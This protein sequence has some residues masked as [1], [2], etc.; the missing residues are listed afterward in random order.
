[1]RT[2]LLFGLGLAAL[3]SLVTACGSSGESRGAFEDPASTEP[4]PIDDGVI[5]G[6]G[7]DAPAP[8]PD[9]LGCAGKQ[10]TEALP[11][12]K[13]LADLSYTPATAEKY[14]LDALDRRYPIG[15]F[16][17]QGGLS[18][19]LAQQQGSCVDR[20]LHDR[21]T[22]KSVLSQ[23][24]T[25]VHE[26]GHFMDLGFGKGSQAAFVI[27]PDV[28]LTCSAGDTTKRGGKTFA[29]SLL[30]KD[31]Y[32][33]KRPACGAQV[34]LG[35]DSYADTYLD[36]SDTNT[37]FESGDQG[38]NS[39]LEEATQY[40]NS[41]ATSLAFKETFQGSKSSQRDG[42]LTFLW[43]VERYLQLAREDHP[44][45]YAALSQD[46]CW[47]QAILTVWDRGWFYLAAT[48]GEENLGLDDT[49]IEPLVRDASLV[50]EIDALRKLE[51]Q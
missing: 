17:V 14:L 42:I 45:A 31:A 20:F 36:G 22:A 37:A 50:A 32:Y 4:A 2:S 47:R 10:Y 9:R 25:V 5:P 26:C 41:L 30:R 8:Q 23:A 7:G 24:Q 48:A 40:V 33:G 39:L 11:S 21:A 16:L 38:F 43:Y 15:K 3:T 13:S 6:G 12:S 44:A 19:S 46:A 1:M 49:A 27:T 29:R 34:D 35:C 18:S 51:C 28:K